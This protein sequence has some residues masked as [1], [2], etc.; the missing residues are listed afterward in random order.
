[1]RWHLLRKLQLQSTSP[2]YAMIILIGVILFMERVT[3]FIL[4]S[5]CRV[6]GCSY[7]FIVLCGYSII[8]VEVYVIAVF[9]VGFP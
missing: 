7:V 3:V 6:S 9:P 2:C 5:L 4:P 8:S 1:M